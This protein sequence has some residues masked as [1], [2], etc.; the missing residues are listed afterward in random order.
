MADL[1]HAP[2][3]WSSV[4]RAFKDDHAL[5]F[6]LYNEP[7]DID[8]KCWRDGCMLPEGW[9]TAGMQRLV[10][11]FA[12]AAPANRSSRPVCTGEPTSRPGS[13]PAPTIPPTS[14]RP[15]S[16]SMTS[17]RARPSTAGEGRP[18]RSLARCP[19]S[20]RRSAS[21]NAQARSSIAHERGRLGRRLLPRLE[22]APVGLAAPALIESWDGR[23]TPP[24]ERLRGRLLALKPMKLR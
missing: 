22:L 5:V 24:G 1:D 3:F 15:A 9:R 23:P 18:I 20:S 8:W 7:H 14:W 2:A 4:A 13:S 11:L 6:D 12:P 19:W 17:P 10:D 16:I 21:G